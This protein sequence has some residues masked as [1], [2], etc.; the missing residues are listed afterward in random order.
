[1]VIVLII[2]IIIIIIIIIIIVI[3][4]IIN[5]LARGIVELISCLSYTTMSTV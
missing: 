2:V 3:I 5:A 4:I 1:M